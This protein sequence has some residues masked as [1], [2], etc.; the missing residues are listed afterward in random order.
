MVT[1]TITTDIGFPILCTYQVTM[2]DFVLIIKTDLENLVSHNTRTVE[3]AKLV[4]RNSR[5]IPVLVVR[6]NTVPQI[7]MIYTNFL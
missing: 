3:C 2:F 7:M 6:H 1:V 4:F 5:P